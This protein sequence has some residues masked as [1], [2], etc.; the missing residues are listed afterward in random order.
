MP[1][2]ADRDALNLRTLVRIRW[3]TLLMIG[4]LVVVGV[5]AS[6]PV[7]TVPIGGILG[8][9]ALS[10]LVLGPLAARLG[11]PAVAGA[12][13]LVDVVGLTAMLALAGGASNPFTALYF[14]CVVVAALLATPR[15]TLATLLGSAGGY[16]FLFTLPAD[17][18]AAHLA[19]HLSGMWAAFVVLGSFFAVAILRL[20]REIAELD[21]RDQEAREVQARARQLASLATLATGAAHE[22]STPLGTIAI[23]SHEL[24]QARLPADAADDARLISEQVDRCRE[25]LEQLAADAGSPRGEPFQPAQLAEFVAEVVEPLGARSGRVE[26]SYAGEG[27]PIAMPRRLLARAV[28]GLVRNALDATEG[29]RPIELRLER[30]P[31]RL[32]V[33][34]R[35]EGEGLTTEAAARVGEPF[36]TT[37]PAGKGMGLGV[38]FARSVARSLGGE[39]TLTGRSRGVEAAVE[40]PVPLET[41]AS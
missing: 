4:L 11:A 36:F 6:W 20:R 18:H 16:G 8:V 30:E 13:V 25:V 7:R 3:V 34:V 38:F 17:P 5:N 35:D 14:L 37:K 29:D 23:A 27:S 9:L 15:W 22:L 24:Q 39:L 1:T 10:N 12:T 28:R 2:P 19:G 41:G 32:R 40:L 21:R 31:S 33:L 26:V